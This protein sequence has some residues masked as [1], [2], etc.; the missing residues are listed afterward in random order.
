M[1]L[2]DPLGRLRSSAP[3]APGAGAS[4][5]TPGTKDILDGL[6]LDPHGGWER[7]VERVES[8]LRILLH[9]RMSARLRDVLT[10]EDLLQ[11][12]WVDA[13]RNLV[14]FEYRGP[15]S[16][17]RWLAGILSNKLLHAGRQ[18]QGVPVPASAVAP[19][20]TLAA[21]MTRRSEPAR[22]HQST[23]SS[24]SG[25][26]RR[27]ELEERVRAVLLRLPEVEREAVLL[28][29]FEGLSGR[30]AAQRLGVDESTVSVRF[31]RA[32]EACA[33]HLKEYAP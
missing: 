1:S 27:R 10:E 22:G 3:E 21:L 23:Q 28:K 5:A 6:A 7:L 25:Q 4:D 11:E 26:A 16:L 18:A 15:G 13:A 29:L 24:V 33:V 31:K 19:E 2:R 14:R 20:S 12:V 17:Q 9:F 32:L 8:R 30:E